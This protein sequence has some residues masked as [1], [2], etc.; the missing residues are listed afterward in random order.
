MYLLQ[1]VHFLKFLGKF[2]HLALLAFSIV[3]LASINSYF[4]FFLFKVER[5]EVLAGWRFEGSDI[6]GDLLVR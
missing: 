5:G 4:L 6:D 2:L 3:S 1:T